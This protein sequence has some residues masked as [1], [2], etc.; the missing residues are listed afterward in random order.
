MSRL[1]AFWRRRVNGLAELSIWKVLARRGTRR[2]A[3]RQPE[4]LGHAV[5]RCLGCSDAARC[6]GLLAQA[7]YDALEAFCPNVMYF[8]HLDAMKR[9]ASGAIEAA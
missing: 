5:E 3:A 4:V 7:K 1:L 8:K 2:I 9:H 6:A